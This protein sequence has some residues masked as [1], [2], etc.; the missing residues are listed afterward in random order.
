MDLEATYL[1]ETASITKIKKINSDK[2][3]AKEA[4]TSQQTIYHDGEGFVRGQL[5]GEGA[6]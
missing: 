4:S 6:R 5:D 2:K 3:S 1:L